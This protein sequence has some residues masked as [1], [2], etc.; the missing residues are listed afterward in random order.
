MPQP[1]TSYDAIVIG[2]GISGGWAAASLRE[3]EALDRDV[4]SGFKV[5][6]EHY[7]KLLTT[8]DR[9][10]TSIDELTAKWNAERDAVKIVREARAKVHALTKETPAEEAEAARKALTDSID[11]YDKV[12]SKPALKCRTAAGKAEGGKD[13][14]GNR[15]KKRQQHANPANCKC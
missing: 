13:H 14:E 2:S 5:D 3:K 8:I 12:K 10:K 9:T 15:R 7:E 4:S 11:A 6:Q 1:N